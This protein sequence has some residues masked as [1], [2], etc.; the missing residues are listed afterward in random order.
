MEIAR[1]ILTIFINILYLPIAGLLFSFSNEKFMVLC[2]SKINTF[3]SQSHHFRYETINDKLLEASIYSFLLFIVLKILRFFLKSDIR[4]LEK[5]NK[6]LADINSS[7]EKDKDKIQRRYEASQEDTYFLKENFENTIKGFLSTFARNVLAFGSKDTEEKNNERITLFTYDKKKKKFT[8]Q[9]RFSANE[10]Y[11]RNGRI[12]YDAGK[13]IIGEALKN[14]ECYDNDFP[15]A[16]NN[17]KI[18]PEY[19]SYQRR[20]YGLS[21]NEV[22]GLTMKSVFMYAYTI[23]NEM[24]NIGV[25]VIESTQKDRYEETFLQE[26]MKKNRKTFKPFIMYA[27]K[28]K[29]RDNLKEEGF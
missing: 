16:Y 21:K 22:L 12:T 11:D 9:V 2:I 8:L 23:K 25:I 3:L 1:K 5:K 10:E 14:D 6:E 15:Q 29:I 24:E 13:G 26:I 27:L 17:N 28:N 20:K 19:I 4:K 18:T 7:L